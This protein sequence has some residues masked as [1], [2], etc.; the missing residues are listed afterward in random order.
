MHRTGLVVAILAGALAVSGTAA[1]LTAQHE[2]EGHISPYAGQEASEIPSLTEQ[3]LDELRSGAGMGLARPAELNHYPGPKHVL[4]LAE[5]LALSSDQLA[6]IEDIHGRMEAA[7]IDAGADV[8]EAERTLNMRFQH[9]HMDEGSLEE[10]VTRIAEL[11][12]RLRFVHLRAH[13]ETTAVLT[14]GQIE[15]YDRLRG[16][17]AADR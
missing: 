16:Y 1:P 3:E 9:G 12:G 15:E 7:A 8:I 2:H 14:P 4:E 6:L 5:E 13:L 10:A 17:A 11:S